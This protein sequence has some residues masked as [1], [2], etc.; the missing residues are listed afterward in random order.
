M[1]KALVIIGLATLVGNSLVLYVTF[2][3]AYFN[4]Y[5]TI[6]FVNN[7]GEANFEFIFIPLCIAIS[8]WTLYELMFKGTFKKVKK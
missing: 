7:Y 6:V 4:D 3:M 8:F 2:L 1:K 5:H